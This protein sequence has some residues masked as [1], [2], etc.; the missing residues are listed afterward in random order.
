MRVFLSAEGQGKKADAAFFF[1]FEKMTSGVGGR[2]VAF[3]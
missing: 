3:F 1:F 2:W